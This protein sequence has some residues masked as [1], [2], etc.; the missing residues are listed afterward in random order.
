MSKSL[1]V[2]LLAAAPAFLTAQFGQPPAKVTG[3]WMDKSLSSDER[4]SLLVKAMSLDEKISL[5]HGVGWD[6]LVGGPATIPARSLGGAGFVPGIPHLGIPDL[7]IADAAVGVAR[8]AI[9]GR[10]STP[11][12]SELAEAA[13]W[14]VEIAREYGALIGSELRDQGY[15]MGLGGGVN[16]TRE[17]RNGRNFEYKGEDPV[18]AGTLAGEEMKALQAQGVIGHIKHYA[19]NDQE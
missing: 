10:Y 9:F 7:Q 13:S 4:A 8:G 12:P 14:N 1:L 16:L 6:Y 15:N 19:M 17:P 2:V 3:P 5:V 11:M 18:L